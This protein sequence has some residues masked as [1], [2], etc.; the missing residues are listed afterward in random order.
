MT[1]NILVCNRN[2]LGRF[3]SVPMFTRIPVAMAK[4]NDNPADKIGYDR[5][6]DR[7]SLIY[8]A[9]SFVSNRLV[10]VM[11]SS[12]LETINFHLRLLVGVDLSHVASKPSLV[13]GGL[14]TLFGSGAWVI[15]EAA[16]LAVF[17][18]EHLIPER[19]FRSLDEAIEELCSLASINSWNGP[20]ANHQLHD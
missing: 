19:D 12:T 2:D 15:I 14:R 9:N 4:S 6:L 13:E 1:S 16:I 20:R 10:I 18:S 8:Q 17:R 11:G 5:S 7:Q 3:I